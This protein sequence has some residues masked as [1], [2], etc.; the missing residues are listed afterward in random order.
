MTTTT[1][2]LPYD[3]P[4]LRQ[5]WFPPEPTDTTVT[6]ARTAQAAIWSVVADAT[7][8]LA[9]ASSPTNEQLPPPSSTKRPTAPTSPRPPATSADAAPCPTCATTSTYC[10][11]PAPP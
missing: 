10:T 2:P 3:L 4:T 5:H 9:T 1:T 7:A 8:E 6:A 11:R